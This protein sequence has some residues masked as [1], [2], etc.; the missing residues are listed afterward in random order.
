MAIREKI[1][2]RTE[3]TD[4]FILN[5]NFIDDYFHEN[6]ICK[7]VNLQFNPS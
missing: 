7:N 3:L 6:V 4:T 1:I 2:R 5:Q